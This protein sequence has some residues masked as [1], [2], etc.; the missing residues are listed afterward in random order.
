[1]ANRTIEGEGGFEDSQ[2]IIAGRYLP[3]N[4]WA[5]KASGTVHLVGFLSPIAQLCRANVQR[6][7][8]ATFLLPF[9]PF[10]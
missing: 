9:R 2:Q 7:T 6:R 8:D 4:A 1:V 5:W 3:V 10:R